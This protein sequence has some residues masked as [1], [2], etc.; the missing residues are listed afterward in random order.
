MQDSETPVEIFKRATAATLRAMSGQDEVEVS[1]S[2]DAPSVVGK[3]VRIPN[4]A[5]DLNP[6]DAAIAR[7]AADAVALK[8]RH[9]DAGIHAYRMPSSTQ[10]RAAFEALE[11]ARV[12]AIGAKEMAGV[13]A[14][15]GAAIDD[16]A[17]RQGFDRSTTRDDAMLPEALKLLAREAMTGEAPPPAARAM[18]DSWR[19]FVAEHMPT[20]FNSLNKLL[21]DQDEYARE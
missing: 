18:V 19:P 17:R 5:R 7:G 20:H 8:L 10:A 4:P 14:N 16:R 12:E 6:R 21:H 9:H 15:L 3:R 2:N 13:A 1:F 11:Q